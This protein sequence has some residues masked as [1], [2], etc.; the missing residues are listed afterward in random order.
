MSRS[1]RIVP[2]TAWHIAEMRGRYRDEDEREAFASARLTA[3]EAVLDSIRRSSVVGAVLDSTG[4]TIAL[5]GVGSPTLVGGV[6]VP[7]M[8]GSRDVDRHSR[9]TITEG[10]R[11]MGILRSHFALLHNYVDARNTKAIRWLKAVG[12]HV[13]PA[14]PYGPFAALFHPF[15]MR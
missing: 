14:V 11:I 13:M 7:W 4:R 12:F 2:A 9:A 1:V 10:R 5:F 3:E 8:M 6:G 15:E